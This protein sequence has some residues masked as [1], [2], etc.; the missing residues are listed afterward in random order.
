MFVIVDFKFGVYFYT[1]RNDFNSLEDSV[2]QISKG[3]LDTAIKIPKIALL[4]ELAL[5]IIS[6][7]EKLKMQIEKLSKL[8]KY[9]TEFIQNVTHEIRTPITAINSAIELVEAN[10]ENLNIQKECFEIIKF[11]TNE[12]NKLVG[13]ILTLGETDLEISNKKDFKSINLNSAI[14]QV[15]NHQGITNCKINF[16]Y[17]KEIFVMADENLVVTAI[18]NLLNN[19]IK[20]SG[21]DT[22]DILLSEEK[23][24]IT[25]EIKD[26]GI[27]ISKNDIGRIFEKFYRVDKSRNKSLG[28]VG[29]GLAIVK[30]IINI[31][32]WMIDV[33]SKE[34][35]Y[36]SFKIYIAN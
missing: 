23:E 8:E 6:M 4:E 19:A 24:L 14:K 3:N 5:S 32:D 34:K 2:V 29:L 27:G 13:D 36:T 25:V 16:I 12:I 10:K 11:Q 30:N 35:E 1:I 9:K 22:I 31:H 21:S 17:E 26:Y 15:I 33:E 20:Y 28:G 18:S 7:T